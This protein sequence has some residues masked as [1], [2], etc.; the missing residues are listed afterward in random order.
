MD[1]FF[2]RFK[3]PL[4]LIAIMIV[5]IIAL[6]VQVPRQ[7]DDLSVGRPDGHKVSLL[8]Y[9]AV[10]VVTPFERVTH[11]GGLSIR[12][13]WSGYVDLR[14]TR[15]QN[16]QLKLE[17]VRLRQEQDAFAED[18]AQG[19]RLQAL[20]AFKQQYISTTVAAQVIGTSGTDRSN[21]VYLD[22]GSEDGLK[23]EQA[24]MTPDG[25]VGKL[26]DVFPHTAQLLLINDA[27][28][29]AGV[30][31]VPSRIRGILRGVANGQMQIN[32]LTQDSRLK[33]GDQVV[34]S[35]GD[36]VFPRGLPIGEVTS[37]VVDPQHQPYTAITIKP[38]A[39]LSRLEE[40]LVITGTQSTLPA[41]AQQDAAQAE[42]AAAENKRAADLVAERLPSLHE[43]SAAKP[44]EPPAET[45]IGGV[46]GVPNSGLPKPQPA[47]RPDKYSPGATPPATELQPGAPRKP[48]SPKVETTPQP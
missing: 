43:D 20:L 14:H 19:R 11:G 10:S 39:N 44:G 25:V 38:Y 33:V 13:L 8:R 34:T 7:A 30:I 35:G 18:A 32:N 46:T 37:I 5:Q 15:Q 27:T 47:L 4:V 6:A 40:V 48:E 29:G 22:K 28:S 1:S 9:W 23:A 17:I 3:N 16:E 24:V 21:V 2:I 26:R 12:H 41:V 42:A 31:V 45:T 36:R